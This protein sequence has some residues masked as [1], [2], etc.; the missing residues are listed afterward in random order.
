MTKTSKTI[1]FFGSGPVAAKSL[2]L[3][4]T[5]FEVEAVVTKPKPTHHKGSFPVID[6]AKKNKLPLH[7]VSDKT[8]LSQL[9]ADKP[10]QSPVG[11]LIDFGIIVSQDVIDYF[12]RGIVNSHFSVLPDLR[13]ADPITFAI[14]SG[15]EVTGVSLMLL[16]Q[17]MDEGPLISYGEYRL[18]ADITTPLLTDHLIQL[19]QA[20]LQ[21]EL[22]GYLDNPNF[23]PA[24]QTITGRQPSYSRKLTKADGT[25]DW[26]KPA[27]QIA[28][29]VRAFIDWPGS[30]TVIADKQ[31]AI[32]SAEVISGSGKPGSLAVDKKS[33][34]IYCGQDALKVLSLKPA[35]KKDMTAEAFI[36]GHKQ[37]LN[38]S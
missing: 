34:I 4:L 17:A 36:N 18:P 9:I 38:K 13:G 27:S 26:Q 23:K 15:Q 22:P 1:V 2:E 21:G 16:V 28:R 30:T 33:L 8:E 19:S 3:L 7:T 35:G 25:I 32:T 12:P 37:L 11:I 14:L 5:T 6:V 31:V 24:P 10:F 20:L 29:E